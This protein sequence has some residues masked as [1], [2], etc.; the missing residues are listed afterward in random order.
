MKVP[1]PLVVLLL[2]AG[3]N[4]DH[5]AP[6]PAPEPPIPP[7]PGPVPPI[8][9]PF[10]LEVKPVPTGASDLTWRQDRYASIAKALSQSGAIPAAQ[11]H[12]AAISIL[13]QWDLATT[14]GKFEFNHNAAALPLPPGEAERY[15]LVDPSWGMPNQP[16]GKKLA[17]GSPDDATFALEFLAALEEYYQTAWAALKKSPATGDWFVALSHSG[18]GGPYNVNEYSDTRDQ[19]AALLATAKGIPLGAFGIPGGAGG[20]VTP[21]RDVGPSDWTK[22][23]SQQ[24]WNTIAHDQGQYAAKALGANVAGAGPPPLPSVTSQPLEILDWLKQ[25]KLSAVFV[26]PEMP[27]SFNGDTATASYDLSDGS[28]VVWTAGSDGSVSYDHTGIGGINFGRIVNEIASVVADVALVAGLLP[29]A[30]FVHTLQAI[31][32]KTS[33]A[34][35]GKAL[36]QDWDIVANEAQLAFSIVDGDWGKTWDLAT[37][38]GQYLEGMVAAFLPGPAPDRDGNLTVTSTT[39]AKKPPPKA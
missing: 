12:D 31:A 8:P 23:T 29:L 39:P 38:E 18:Y 33:L 10:S 36:K 21:P 37:K 22:K 28:H 2:V 9:A 27:W 14:A 25:A 20:S 24:K 4:E 35:L 17:A 26:Y 19:L 3:G 11:Q 7:R 32:N 5:H 15:F 1:W 16:A 34:D 6:S 30:M 13:T